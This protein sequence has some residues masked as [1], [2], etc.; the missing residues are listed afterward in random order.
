MELLVNT[1]AFAGLGSKCSGSEERSEDRAEVSTTPQVCWSQNQVLSIN[2]H[3]GEIR[4]F[5]T[6]MTF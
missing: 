2:E 4:M 3:R 5:Y 1:W 6:D